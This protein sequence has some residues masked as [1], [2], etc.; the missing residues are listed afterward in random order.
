MANISVS[1]PSDGE[2]VDV[3]DYN[4]PINTIVNEING[5]LDNSNITAAAAIAG[6]KLADASVPNAKLATGSGE[7]GGEWTAYTPTLSGYSGTPTI[8]GRWTQ[9][10]KTVTVTV[11]ISGTSNATT[12]YFTY[13]VAP[14][15]WQD[16]IRFA[17]FNTSNGTTTM[18]GAATHRTST[19]NIEVY[20]GFNQGTAT[21]TLT[22]WA[23]SGTAEYSATFTYQA[24]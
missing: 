22:G 17:L 7:A 14:A 1:L 24:A 11:S 3:A 19:P 13:P 10:G 4:T 2:T 20:R 9:V 12:K 16:G 23:T 8:V 18:V 21:S 5:S 6:S 15:T